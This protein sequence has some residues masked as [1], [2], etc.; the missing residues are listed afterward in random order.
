MFNHSDSLLEKLELMENAIIV[1]SESS[2]Q[3]N[4]PFLPNNIFLTPMLS[5][6]APFG[7]H[8]PLIPGQGFPQPISQ[9]TNQISTPHTTW[10][11]E[12]QKIKEKQETVSP[13]ST[14]WKDALSS[15]SKLDILVEKHKELQQQEDESE[16]KTDNPTIEQEVM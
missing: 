11:Q 12:E 13:T 6:P 2:P 3:Q 14:T 4:H 7:S 10:A 1:N 9:T 15:K 5:V 16:E 8:F